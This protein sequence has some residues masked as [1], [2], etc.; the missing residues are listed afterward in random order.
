MNFSVYLA[1]FAADIF[2]V[3]EKQGSVGGDRPVLGGRTKQSA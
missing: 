1:C 2:Y 3:K